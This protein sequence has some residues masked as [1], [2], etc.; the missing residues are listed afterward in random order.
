MDAD[1]CISLAYVNVKN[2]AIFL[3]LELSSPPGGLNRKN[4]KFWP[5]YKRSDWN[6]WLAESFSETP[7]STL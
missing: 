3:E 4:L 7:T 1:F 2:E 6:T 5:Y